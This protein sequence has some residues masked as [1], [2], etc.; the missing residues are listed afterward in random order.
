MMARS[1][2]VLLALG[3]AVAP[4]AGAAGRTLRVDYYHFTRDEV[5]FCRV[6]QRAIARVIDLCSTQP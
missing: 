5:P 3:M 6:C 2:V 4:S 1:L